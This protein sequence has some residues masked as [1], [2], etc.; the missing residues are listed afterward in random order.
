MSIFDEL[1]DRQPPQNDNPTKSTPLTYT[2]T[3]VDEIAGDPIQKM[4]ASCGYS[5]RR[6]TPAQCANESIGRLD[7][8]YRDANTIKKKK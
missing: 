2:V 1:N 3:F 6:S 5:P 8:F 4:T 7:V